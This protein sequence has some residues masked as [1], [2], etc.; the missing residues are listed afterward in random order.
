MPVFALLLLMAGTSPLIAQQQPP[1]PNS[2]TSQFA[3]LALTGFGLDLWHRVASETPTGNLLFSPASLSIALSLTYAGATGGTA[4]AFA[5]TLGVSP[6]QHEAYDSVAGAWLTY[7]KAQKSVEFSMANS[8]WASESFPMLANYRSRMKALY[9]AELER[10]DL[11][12]LRSVAMINRWVSRETRGKIPTL[13]KDPPLEVDTGL[14]LL[15]ALYFKGKW[16]YPFDS[17]ATRPRPFHLAGG[18]TEP[19]PSMERTAKLG[20]LKAE[21]YRGLR[22]PYADGRFAMYVLMPDSGVGVAALADS[23][24]W[25]A[26]MARYQPAEVRVVLPKFTVRSDFNLKPALKAGGLGVAF[27]KERAEFYRMI[28]E[29]G[30]IRAWIVKVSQKTMMQVSEQGT[31]AAAATAVVM[32]ATASASPPPIDFV[33]DRPFVVVLRDERSGMFL[34]I[35]RIVDPQ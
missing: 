8:L 13:F 28:P 22:L 32:A 4:D 24:S 2:D 30:Q 6:S 12:S 17:T 9:G 33:V 5:R 21:G 7:L 3:R 1:H 20:Y 35:G 15:N 27:D 31:E 29:D 26:S 25:S 10:V 19:R 14:V 16:T 34:F 18:R 23:T 11:T